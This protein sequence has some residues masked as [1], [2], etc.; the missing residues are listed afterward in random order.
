M[1]VYCVN[2]W[3]KPENVQ[4]FIAATLKNAQNTIQEPDNFRFDV[5][6]QA[7]DPG[8]FILY[9]V[10]RDQ[11]AV[12]SHRQTAHYAAW[13]DAVAGWM[14]QPRQGVKYSPLFPAEEEAWSTRRPA[15]S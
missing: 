5:I 7:D 10:Y 12:D 9:E 6:Q 15:R 2:I 13:R 14:A 3:V 1:L 11:A 8:H 4:E